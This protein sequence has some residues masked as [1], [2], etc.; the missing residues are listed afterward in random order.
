[1][2]PSISV[3]GS[4]CYSREWGLMANEYNLLLQYRTLTIRGEKIH[5]ARDSTRTIRGPLQIMDLEC[6]ASI[7]QVFCMFSMRA[8]HTSTILYDTTARVA[9]PHGPDG[10][11]Q[12]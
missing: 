5:Y 6:F 8:K 3:V 12:A 11:T 7:L 4:G 9:S 2:F 10:P 1:M